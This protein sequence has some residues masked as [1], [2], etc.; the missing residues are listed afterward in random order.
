MNSITTP[1]IGLMPLFLAYYDEVLPE[2][3]PQVDRFAQRIA[4]ELSTEDVR[5]VRSPVCCLEPEVK[6]ALSDFDAAG[7]DLIVTLHLAYST[8]LDAAPLLAES[9]LPVVLLDT[10]P[11]LH[12]GAEA[13]RQDML[14]GH[15]IHGVQDLASMLRR[16]GKDYA[17]VAGHIENSD[18]L[19]QVRRWARA[20]AAARLFRTTKVALVGHPFVGMGDFSVDFTAL[21]EILGPVVEEISPKKLGKLAK[22]VTA[23]QLKAE[24]A[25][26]RERFD[27]G[28]VSDACLEHSARSG[29]ALRRAL[30]EAE[31][32]AFSMNF[33]VFDSTTGLETV[34]FLEAS[35]AMS[36]GIGYAGE[37]DVLTASLVG[38]LAKAYGNTTFTEMFCAD[39][40]GG[41]VFMS[42][43]GECNV[44]MA[45]GR[46]ILVEKSYDFGDVADP[47]V[48]VFKFVPGPATLVN[49]SP[50]PEQEFDLI[51]AQVDVVD[52]GISQ[53]FREAPHFW[54]RPKDGDVPAFLRRYSEFGGTHHLALVRGIA[55]ADIEQLATCLGMEFHEV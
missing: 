47:A 11:A 29:L 32:D 15:G 16:L 43:M 53:E 24:I 36:R 35:K 8:S 34:P 54:I 1:T 10:T 12:F 50:G 3:K 31:A 26:D 33:Q 7:V 38:A 25:A 19:D 4:A 9:N 17:V 45:D 20:A 52:T 13:T 48:A 30:D 21:E 27:C 6:E 5:V 39:W 41:T 37:G 23:E 51:A 40:A 49:I 44:D 46:A 42:H 18:V 55:P 14:E 22:D 28:G 2:L